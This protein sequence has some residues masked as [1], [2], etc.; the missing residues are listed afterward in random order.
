MTFLHQIRTSTSAE[1]VDEIVTAAILVVVGRVAKMPTADVAPKQSGRF[2]GSVGIDGASPQ[3]QGEQD[4]VGSAGP[5]GLRSARLLI[6][7]EAP[8]EDG[9]TDAFPADKFVVVA[10]VV[11]PG[12]LAVDD[13]H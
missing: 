12:N 13:T 8:S 11:D 7:P 4:D 5:G 6:G 1:M 3:R 2:K 9:R 10:R